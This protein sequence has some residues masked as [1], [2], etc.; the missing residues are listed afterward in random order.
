[1]SAGL[2]VALHTDGLVERPGTDIGEAVADAAGRLLDTDGH[3]PDTLAGALITHS[4]GSADHS[5]DVAP[6][7]IHY[8]ARG[9]VP[10]GGT[11]RPL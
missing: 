8:R 6:L 5:D 4:S 1:M 2:A 9:G 7:L 10:A 3:R 11:F